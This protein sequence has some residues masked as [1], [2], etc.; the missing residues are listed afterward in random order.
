LET[1]EHP[2]A[3]DSR[4]NVKPSSSEIL[5]PRELGKALE[6]HDT[7]PRRLRAI[8]QEGYQMDYIEHRTFKTQFLVRGYKKWPPNTVQQG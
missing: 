1:Q 4:E 6:I 5:E 3:L 2:N 7:V 8:A